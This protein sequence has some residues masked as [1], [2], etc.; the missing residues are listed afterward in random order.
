MTYV[1]YGS[2]LLTPAE[3]RKCLEETT[4]MEFHE[5][6]SMYLGGIYYRTGTLGGKRFEITGNEPDETGELLEPE[7]P[8][9]RSLL[10]ANGVPVPTEL[11]GVLEELGLV[12]LES[13]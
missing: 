10:R 12:L 7:Y 4:G 11:H 1:M 13:R 8:S 6:E 3:L 5:R 9:F 2:E